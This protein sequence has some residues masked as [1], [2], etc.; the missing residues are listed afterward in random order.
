MITFTTLEKKFHA[1]GARVHLG[2]RPKS[3]SRFS[4]PLPFSIDIQRD[5]GGEFFDIGVSPVAKGLKLEVLDIQEEDQHLLLLAK[6]PPSTGSGIGKPNSFQKHKFLC[7]HDERH[8][9]VAAIPESSYGV[10]NVRL[11]KNALKPAMVLQ[12]LSRKGIHP[13]NQNRRKNKGY[14]R[15]GEWFFIPNPDLNPDSWRVLRNEP[16]TRGN[17]GKPHC[18]EYAYRLGGTRVYVSASHSQGLSE[19]QYRGYLETHP[20]SMTSFRVMIKEPELYAKGRVTHA[21]H[22]T[23]I[24]EGW[25]RV[26]MNTENQAR[27]MS[28]VVFLD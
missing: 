13:K 7:G 28:N 1:I 18:L 27:A 17:G 20:K 19:A 26:L 21:D 2:S 6:N 10:C 22:K 11:A 15:Q 25:H 14:C 5:Q 23:V 12:E 9:F 4:S 3:V 24:L 16:I 8:W